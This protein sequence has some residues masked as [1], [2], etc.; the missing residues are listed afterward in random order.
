MKTIFNNL[1]TEFIDYILSFLYHGYGENGFEYEIIQNG[2][3]YDLEIIWNISFKYD[4]EPKNY[5]SQLIRNYR[6]DW[7]DFYDID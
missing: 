1:S 7:K 4:D 6:D 5:V 2:N 3:L